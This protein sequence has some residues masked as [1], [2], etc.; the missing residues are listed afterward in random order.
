MVEIISSAD[1]LGRLPEASF[2]DLSGAGPLDT[3]PGVLEAATDACQ[4][5]LRLRGEI[6]QA[7]T[8][9]MRTGRGQASTARSLQR[10]QSMATLA[11]LVTSAIEIDRRPLARRSSPLTSVGRLLRRR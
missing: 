5:A 9:A 2:A 10:T 3:D 8:D 4:L 6:D 1:T 11:D 7:V